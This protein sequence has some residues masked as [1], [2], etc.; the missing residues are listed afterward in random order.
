METIAQ[1]LSVTEAGTESA[2]AARTATEARREEAPA[3]VGR[4]VTTARLLSG[5]GDKAGWRAR[6]RRRRRRDVITRGLDV[7]AVRTRDVTSDGRHSARGA[8]GRREKARPGVTITH[9]LRAEMVAMFR[10]RSGAMWDR[11]SEVSR[12]SRGRDATKADARF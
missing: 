11:R 7:P 2:P 6:V 3:R 9:V 8:R 10:T 1:A 4:A 12:H 5:G